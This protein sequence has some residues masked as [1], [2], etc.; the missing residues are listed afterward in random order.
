MV[1]VDESHCHKKK[2]FFTT[3]DLVEQMNSAMGVGRGG[4]A[5]NDENKSDD[6][7]VRGFEL[8]TR[9]PD[10]SY[11]P[12][13]SNELAAVDFQSKMKQAAESIVGLD[14]RQKLEWASRQRRMGNE[15]FAAGEYREA[16]DVYLTCL[17]AVDRGGKRASSSS[18]LDDDGNNI[19]NKSMFDRMEEEIQ[20]PVL[21]NLALSAMKMGMLGKAEKFCNHAIDETSCG[22]LSPKA[23]FR[24]GRVRLLMGNYVDA[25]SDLDAALRLLQRLYDDFQEE[26]RPNTASVQDGEVTTTPCDVIVKRMEDIETERMVILREKERLNSLVRQAERAEK[27]QKRA[28]ERLFGGLSSNLINEGDPSVK[29]SLYPEKQGLSRRHT[30]NID[31]C[32]NE[33]THSNKTVDELLPQSTYFRWYMSMIGRCAQKLLDLIGEAEDDDDDDSM[34]YLANTCSLKG[35]KDA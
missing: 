9:M 27:V 7:E 34:L 24:R 22:K 23:Y 28:M 10:G 15:L 30:R 33:S 11:R 8:H 20:L 12:T 19:N 6:D 13:Q 1:I 3:S 35:E 17:V 5:T 4:A 18:L 29:S 14:G 16:M 31:G 2:M 26:N 21:L 25:E 32:N